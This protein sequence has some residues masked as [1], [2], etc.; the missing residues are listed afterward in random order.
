MAVIVPIFVVVPSDLQIF[1]EIYVL[2]LNRLS[3]VYSGSSK[4]HLEK[5]FVENS[6]DRLSEEM[7]NFFVTQLKQSGS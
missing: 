7:K 4:K 2:S 5:G 6:S 3:C 1:I